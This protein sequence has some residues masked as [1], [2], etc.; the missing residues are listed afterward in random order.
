MTITTPVS[1][2][3]TTRQ[4]PTTSLRW[5]HYP[6]ES[7]ARGTPRE[8]Q[9]LR[10]SIAPSDLGQ[11]NY[12]TINSVDEFFYGYRYVCS[13]QHGKD[14]WDQV[15]LTLDDVLYPQMDDKMMQSWEHSEFGTLLY[16]VIRHYAM[17]QPGMHVLWDVGM[18]W[19]VAGARNPVPDI[20]VLIGIWKKPIREYGVYDRA[21]YG[22]TPALAV[23]LTPHST[24]YLDVNTDDSE[25]SK[26]IIYER[27]GVLY[28]V[29][30]DTIKQGANDTPPF[31]G[32]ELVQGA[33]QRRQPDQ[34]G[35]LWIPSVGVFL[36]TY[37]QSL[38]WF[39]TDGT[40]LLSL[41]EQAQRAEQAEARPI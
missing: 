17:H 40:R 19:R 14:V 32:Y 12:L 25:R 4:G 33:Y 27:L 37:E 9:E 31:W 7:A 36:G 6:E 20:L 13:V 15:P 28:Y 39:D 1:P 16:E 41:A 2:R 10:Q 35:R 24:R 29:V 26:C 3:P 34:H 5:H 22:G 23:E 8:Q 21:K 38:A 18:D 11:T 30:I